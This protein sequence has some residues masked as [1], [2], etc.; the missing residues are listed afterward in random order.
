MKKNKNKSKNEKSETEDLKKSKFRENIEAILI[1]VVLALFI[2]TFFIESYVI[3]TGSMLET[4]QLGDQILVNKF[5]YG[6][7]LPFIQK[8]LLPI[9]DPD[10]GDIVVFIPPHDPKN[11]YI[12]RVIGIAG[13]I[14]QIRD[15]QLFVNGEPVNG[16]YEVFSDPNIYS[17][18]QAKR[19]NFGPL[20]VPDNSLFFMG[21]NRDSSFDSRFWGIVDLKKVRGKALITYWSWNNKKKKV[22]WNRIGKF[23]E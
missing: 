17:A 6:V 1:A 21:D 11:P 23:V 3:P 20:T 2:R 4:I 19:D 7:K 14:I 10:R 12:K 5:I 22:R 16:G 13:D 8:T 9:T 15:K 18:R